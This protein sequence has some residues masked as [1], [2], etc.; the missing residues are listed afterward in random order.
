[1]R[2]QVSETPF[3]RFPFHPF[4]I[5][6]S[7]LARCLPCLPCP[8][9]TGHAARR[10]RQPV[11]LFLFFRSW[12][13]LNAKKNLQMGPRGVGPKSWACRSGS[14]AKPLSVLSSGMYRPLAFTRQTAA[15]AAAARCKGGEGGGGGAA[16]M[17]NVCDQH[18]SSA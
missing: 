17:G 16:F 10:T 6:L 8:S 7:C 18:D 2:E 4:N 9:P 12:K 5:S 3:H 15:A 1:M 11:F 14:C 13:S